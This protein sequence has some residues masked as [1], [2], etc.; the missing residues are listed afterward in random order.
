MY[1]NN[2]NKEICY[3]NC[4]QYSSYLLDL[5][6]TVNR[7]TTATSGRARARGAVLERSTGSPLV[8]DLGIGANGPRAWH[9]KGEGG[10]G[11]GP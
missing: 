5:V 3:H 2:S 8:A 7:A 10:N 4:Q 9:R 1:H 11:R 6:D